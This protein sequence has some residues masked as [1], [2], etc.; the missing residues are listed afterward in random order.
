MMGGK[1]TGRN[2][3]VPPELVVEIERVRASLGISQADSM[4]LLLKRGDRRFEEFRI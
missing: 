1:R 3:Y 4:R 2:M